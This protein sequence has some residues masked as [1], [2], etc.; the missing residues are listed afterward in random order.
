MNINGYINEEKKLKDSKILKKN[1]VL[2]RCNLIEEIIDREHRDS[3]R[4]CFYDCGEKNIKRVDTSIEYPCQ[5]YIL[6]KK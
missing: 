1:K 4:Q 3:E 5:N 6:E 2:H